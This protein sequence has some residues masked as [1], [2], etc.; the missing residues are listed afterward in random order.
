MSNLARAWSV[1][2][3]IAVLGPP[4]GAILWPILWGMINRSLFSQPGLASI[5]PHPHF[6]LVTFF[7]SYIGGG[8]PALFV[9][10]YAARRTFQRGSFSYVEACLPIGV[11]FVIAN[12]FLVDWRADDEIRIWRGL[13]L[14]A[15]L[16]VLSV[17]SAIIC[18]FLLG[19]F[20]ILKP[21]PPSG[22]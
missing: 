12:L 17:A 6:V 13:R 8:L 3:F 15:H 22:A 5:W 20:G 19:W 14:I 16:A 18:R 10:L 9:G 2:F 11:L 7:V 21:T 1:F 4:I